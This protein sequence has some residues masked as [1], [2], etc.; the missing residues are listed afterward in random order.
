MLLCNYFILY[1]FE[2]WFLRIRPG[3]P[4]VWL[5]RFRLF[6]QD[7]ESWKK[8][9]P[10]LGSTDGFSRVCAAPWNCWPTFAWIDLHRGIFLGVVSSQVIKG[11][12][13][14]PKTLLTVHCY[15]QKVEPSLCNLSEDMFSVAI[16]HLK[17]KTKLINCQLQHL[18]EISHKNLDP[19]L[20]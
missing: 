13:R 2:N 7:S 17:N 19:A 14:L 15:P 18:G 6:W 3:S 5:L 10:N 11:L 4:F 16:K 12:L 9:Y 8:R 1:S 20:G